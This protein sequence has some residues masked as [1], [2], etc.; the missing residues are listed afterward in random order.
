MAATGPTLLRG[1]VTE[2]ATLKRLTRAKRT[3]SLFLHHPESKIDMTV[4]FWQRLSG[5]A[6]VGCDIA[7]VGGG[8]IGVS[9]A[10]W[11]RRLRPELKV[12]LVEAGRLASGAS[13]RNAGFLL[14]GTAT[15][16]VSDMARYGAEKARRLWQFTRENRDLIL[17]TLRGRAF[18]LEE[19]GSLIV[20]GSVEEDTRLQACVSPMRADGLPVAYLPAAEVRRRIQAQGFEGALYVP[21]GAMVN[22]VQLVQ[23]IAAESGAQV[24]EYHRVLDLTAS[25]GRLRLDTVQRR[26]RA[27]Q[28]V[29]CLN[30]YLPQILPALARYVRPV[31]AQMLATE[32]LPP[33][34]L[35]VPVYTHEGFFYLR[36][37]PDSTLL[38]GGARHLHVDAEVGYEDQ[39]TAALQA[40]LEAYLIRHFS[41]TA[42]FRVKQRWS[43]TMG[44]SPDHLPVVGQVPG[45]PGSLFATGFTG[46]GMGFGFRFG[47]LLAETALGQPH[48]E[49]L[50]LFT[51]ARFST[52]T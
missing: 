7:V 36:Q 1:G 51:A 22:P 26:V 11:L 10:Y 2:R 20:A 49:G 29:L 3:Q 45:L 21:S 23:H 50:D 33:R 9:T 52:G 31:R 38:L 12:V 17:G 27:S 42:G 35:T 48:P 40:D 39:T 4:S 25:R 19:S 5:D 15:D 18:S 28:V 14:Q 8:I 43:G 16:Y 30:A 44:F 13:G 37:Q 24:L 47:R 32:P 41:H 6:D 46:H 34:W